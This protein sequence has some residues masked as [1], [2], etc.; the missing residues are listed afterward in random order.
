MLSLE[1]KMQLFSFGRNY[2][3]RMVEYLERNVKA[4]STKYLYSLFTHIYKKSF[5][6]RTFNFT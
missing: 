4:V 6:K 3:D 1:G 5:P 2:D